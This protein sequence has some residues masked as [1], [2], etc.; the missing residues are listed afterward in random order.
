MNFI[1]PKSKRH[2]IFRNVYDSDLYA[3][4]WKYKDSGLA[5]PLLVDIELTNHCNLKCFF[6]GQVAMARKKGFITKEVFKKAVD[7]CALHKTP[8]RLIR[9][10]EP[11]LHAKAIEFSSY[12][13][14]RGL[15]VHITTNGL[16]L[17]K[18]QSLALLEMQLDSIKFSF[19]GATKERYQEIRNTSSY[20]VLKRNIL[21]L[22]SLRKDKEKPYIHI[23]STM[24]NETKAQI[25]GFLKYW[26]EIVDSVS[27]GRTNLSLFHSDRILDARQRGLFEKLKEKETLKKE[28]RPCG[29]VYRQLSVDWDGKVSACCSDFDNELTVGHLRDS[30]LEKIWKQSAPLKSIRVLLSRGMFRSLTKCSS[31]FQYYEDINNPGGTIKKKSI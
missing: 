14:S 31:C 2:N 23:S 26:G 16:L 21:E 4:A 13:K 1:N 28:Y 19:Q 6:C 9:W 30:T 5:F 22:V 10:G 3:N 18:R 20:D 12:A 8:I 15:S 25:D 29:E 24:T 17:K 7:E 11:F 27:I